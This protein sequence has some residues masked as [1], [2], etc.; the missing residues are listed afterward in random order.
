MVLSVIVPVYKVEPFLRKCVDS[1]INQTYRNLEII[2]VDDG[3]P[4]NCGAICDEYAEKDNRVFVIHKNNG[5]VSSTRNVGIEQAKGDY[6]T[7]VDSDD[8]LEETMYE[9]MIACA[10]TKNADVVCCNYQYGKWENQDTKQTYQYGGSEACHK[11]FESNR[12]VDGISVAPIDK[13]FRRDIVGSIRFCE[14]CSYAEDTLFV[15][16]VLCIANCVVKLDKTFYHYVQVEGSA[17]RSDY[18]IQ[19]SSEI[20]AYEKCIETANKCALPDLRRVFVS[21]CFSA[22]LHHWEE[23]NLRKRNNEFRIRRDEIENQIAGLYRVYHKDLPLRDKVKFVVFVGNKRVYCWL[24]KKWRN[25][26]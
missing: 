22:A 4:D 14:Q 10:K 19:R 6:I 20:I 2:L 21:K 12:L 23:C 7:F 9:E 11:M 13:I 18:S 1:I 3:S 17:M 26:V 24:M 25:H 5:G 8:W 16:E 15:T